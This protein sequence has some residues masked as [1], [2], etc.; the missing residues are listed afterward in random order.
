MLAPKIFVSFAAE[1]IR[2]RDLLVGQM[3]RDGCPFQFSDMS[4]TAPFDA[5]WKSQC[6]ERIQRCDGFIA[7]LSTSTWRA[8]GAKWEMKCAREELSQ[9][10]GVHIHK[11]SKGAIPTE[12]K[13]CRIIDWNQ[14]K[15][16]AFVKQV[17]ESRHFLDRLLDF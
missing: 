11:T 7:L 6:R 16:A 3:E 5:K 1:D 12:L 2:Y 15:L 8:S 10:L 9:I 13:G 4:L 14:S 17:D